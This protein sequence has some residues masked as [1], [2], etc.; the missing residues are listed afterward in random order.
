VLFVYH[1]QVGTGVTAADN[2]MIA[3]FLFHSFPALAHLCFM[4]LPTTGT[5]QV[6][7]FLDAAALAQLG[8]LAVLNSLP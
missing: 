1:A 7:V 8:S 2:T 5:E 6:V 4:H 3:L